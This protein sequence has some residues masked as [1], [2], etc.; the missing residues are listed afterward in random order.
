MK[1]VAMRE[2]LLPFL[3]KFAEPESLA[4][5]FCT[6]L[7]QA[8]YRSRLPAG[9]A[10][11]VVEGALK[12]CLYL[13]RIVRAC[14]LPSPER[15]AKDPLHPRVI[16]MATQLSHEERAELGSLLL[17]YLHG[18]P[19]SAISLW[20]QEKADFEVCTLLERYLGTANEGDAESTQ[21]RADRGWSFPERARLESR[22]LLPAGDGAKLQK[23]ELERVIRF[24][25]GRGGKLSMELE[26]QPEALAPALA[27]AG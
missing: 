20:W 8:L 26:E 23:P 9:L 7:Y 21:H 13:E 11:R 25:K 24:R 1:S 18:K 3:K 6:S 22:V 2:L 27:D 14:E 16:R 5:Y 10:P 15:W 19:M 17:C 4:P 12:R